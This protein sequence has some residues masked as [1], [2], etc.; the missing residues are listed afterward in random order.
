MNSISKPFYIN[1]FSIILISCLGIIVYS[2]ALYCS[3]HFD[4]FD[5]IVNNLAIR[6][7]QDLQRIWEYF[8]CRFVTFFSFAINYHFHQF[9][10]FGYHLFNIAVHLCSAILVWWLVLLT[11]A[12]PGMK[13]DKITQHANLI[14]LFTGLVFVSQPVQIESVTYILQRAAS[15]STMFYLASLCLYIKSRSVKSGGIYYA[16]SLIT[17]MM[18]MFTKETSITLPLVI[19]LYEYMFLKDN[20]GLNWRRLSP[21]LL[22]FF[23]IPSIT[24]LTNSQ[25]VQY[26]HGTPAV[27][28]GLSSVQYVMTQFRVL[29]T[30]VRLVFI[31][32]NQ[33]FD[34]D[35][36]ISRSV[37]ELPTLFSIIFLIFI[38]YFVQRLY[39]K[40]KLVSFSIAW[41]FLGLLPESIPFPVK[42]VIFEHRLYLSMV[43]YSMFL[44]V[45]LYYLLGKN[46]LRTMGIVLT[47][48]IICYSVLTYQRNKI[49][50]N[51]ATLWN[52][53]VQKSPNKARPYNFRGVAYSDKKDFVYAINDFS[54]AIEIDPTLL[55]AY[56]NRADIYVQQGNF[57]QAISDYNKAIKINPALAVLF[58]NRGLL[59]IKQGNF[60]KAV[61]DFT[62]V[63]KIK[64]KFV[65]AYGNLGIILANQGRFTQ[66]VSVFTKAI[67][68]E[69]NYAPAFYNRGRLYYQLKEYDRS[70]ADV[71]K[72]EEL[73]VVSNSGF[74]LDLKKASGR[75]K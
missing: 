25:K 3:F 60:T 46:A 35:Y 20:G 17:A 65:P 68:I 12:T 59:Y 6:N 4:D 18:A 29:L 15:M 75:D 24:L 58:Y 37:L 71:H 26:I 34:Y 8:P 44:V 55:E 5:F 2:N 27:L 56:N 62:R 74:I 33:N 41:F 38:P 50:V 1:F 52:D 49:W 10:I 36:P 45:S 67:E 30:Y 69:P 14:A 19:L 31:P 61:S 47:V 28:G 16:C 57:A 72:A 7:I 73:G 21:F 40:Y 23:M 70:W 13:G 63:I 39:P 66:A 22:A 42:D 64:P 11:L 48:I 54:K 43:G 32:L 53:A 51:E 9:N